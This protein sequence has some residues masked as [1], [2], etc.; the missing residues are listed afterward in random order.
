MGKI[1]KSKSKNIV[2]NQNSKKK[3]K[4]KQLKDAKFKV[5]KSKGTKDKRNRSINFA[6]NDYQKKVR[7]VFKLF[8][9][10]MINDLFFQNSNDRNFKIN[11]SNQLRI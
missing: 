6:K 2:K 7:F 8:K 1:N 5:T 3:S 10:I 9:L 4:D 11:N